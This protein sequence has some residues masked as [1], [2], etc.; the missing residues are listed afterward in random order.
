MLRPAHIV[1]SAVLALVFVDSAAAWQRGPSP[2]PPSDARIAKSFAR[3]F[4]KK[5]LSRLPLDDAVSAR[6]WTNYLAGYDHDHVYFLESDIAAFRA[7][8]QGLDDYLMRGDSQFAYEVF[9]VFRQRVRNR[10]EYVDTLL[11]KGFNLDREEFYRWKRKDSPRPADETEWNEIWRRKIK[12]EYVRLLVERE[13][14]GETNSTSKAIDAGNEDAAEPLSPS[15]VIRDRYRQ[16]LTMI[17]DSDSEWVLERYLSAFAR[18]YD[19]HSTY[20]SPSSVENFN[21]EMKLSLVGI[22]ALLRSEDGAAKVVRIIPG[23]PADRDKSETRLRPGDKIVAVAQGGGPSVNILHQPLYRIV[24]LIRGKKGTRVVLSVIPASDPSGLT[25]KKVALIRDEVKLEEQ[26]A[27]FRIERATGSDTVQRQLAVITLPTFYFNM[28]AES[29]DDPHYRSSAHDVEKILKRVDRENAAGVLLDLRNN[30]GGSLIE[31]AQ[32]AG[33]F[34]DRGPVVQVKEGGR[35]KVLTDRRSGVAYSRP[36]V[37]LVNRLSASASEILAGA[38][39]D[40]GRA[41]ILGDSKTH[42]KGTVQ[43]VLPLGRD[44]RLGAVKITTASYYRVSG[45]STQLK[46]ILPDVVVPSAFDYM[47]LGEDSLPTA[48][49]WSTVPQSRYSPV[50]DLSAV[51]RVLRDKSEDRRASDPR[52]AAYMRLLARI[53]A[54]NEADKLPL[55]LTMRKELAKTERKLSELHRSLSSEN[56]DGR[57]EGEDDRPD[58]VLAEC[59]RILADLVALREEG[60]RTAPLRSDGNDV[61]SAIGITLGP[62]SALRSMALLVPLAAAV[63]LSSWLFRRGHRQ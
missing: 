51:I 32:M 48:I 33:L 16:F 8:E 45:W 24:K 12:N 36:L 9:E 52:F 59:L 39:Q 17:S 1:L 5:H 20:M 60:Q 57:E 13:Q 42:G 15:E 41:V 26:A 61:R 3:I 29:P 34:I 49:G 31:A 21:I 35:I 11:T 22:G 47:D 6:A 25:T 55:Q 46:G 28:K 40:Y 53:E 2:Q 58:F 30:G 27:K 63:V 14:I 23:G 19:P 56:K 54:I 62:R 10:N 50:D 44:E 43:T 4:P 7:D 37:V 38:L 18:A